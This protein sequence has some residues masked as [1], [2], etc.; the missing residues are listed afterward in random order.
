LLSFS[1][2]INLILWEEYSHDINIWKVRH[3]WASYLK[4]KVCDKQW[5]IIWTD[6][7]T[8]PWYLDFFNTATR[9]F[10][11]NDFV[12]AATGSF[13]AYLPDDSNKNVRW[14]YDY[15]HTIWQLYT[16]LYSEFNPPDIPAE[17]LLSL[18]PWSCSIFRASVYGESG[19]YSSVWTGEDMLF[20]RQLL[21]DEMHVLHNDNLLVQSAFRP[22]DRTE[23]WFGTE[24][25][26]VSKE[27]N[28]TVVPPDAIIKRYR[29]GTI[30][31]HVW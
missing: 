15:T 22:S 11:E 24:P 18:M 1:Q 27:D 20:S 31:K 19:N 23:Y 13:I 5:I 6:A 9:F 10:D 4:W 21:E 7:D 28:L 2:N 3:L 8:I 30:F 14:L 29:V 16:L 26:N 12:Q 17:E 25:Y